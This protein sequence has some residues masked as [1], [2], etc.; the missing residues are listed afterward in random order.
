RTRPEVAR[1]LASRD[2]KDRSEDTVAMATGENTAN[3]AG[4]AAVRMRTLKLR[5]TFLTPAFLGDAEQNARWRTP[6]FKHLLRE[7]WRVRF[8]AR[9]GQGVASM[10]SVEGRLF[11]HAWLENDAWVDERGNKRTTAARKSL[12]RIR[13]LPADAARPEHTWLGASQVGV[14]PLPTSVE[15]GYAWFGL[16]RRGAGQPDRRALKA[17]ETRVLAFAWPIRYDEDMHETLRLVHSFGTVGSRSRGGWGSVWLS[18]M[19]GLTQE[20]LLPYTQPLDRCLDFDWPAAIA[21]AEDGKPWLWLSQTAF[22]TWDEA[23]KQSAIWRRQVRLALKG[24]P[25]L[26]A[27]LGFAGSGRMPSPL[28]WKVVRDEQGKLRLQVVA[29]PHKI[30]LEAGQS[31]SK[32]D[33]KRAW[34][35]IRGEMNKLMP[36]RR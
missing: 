20:E 22:R 5:C 7:W 11:G 3:D 29:M 13:L 4:E 12:V 18:D 33:L 32:D 34:Q 9:E 16:V 14:A 35:V 25:D 21:R 15:T 28:R 10:R 26:R 6:P 23:L 31:F 8:F 1:K 27:A 19:K 30:P 2:A 17:G 24:R 36:P